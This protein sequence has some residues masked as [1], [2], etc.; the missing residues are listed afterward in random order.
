MGVWVSLA[1]VLAGG[2]SFLAFL[3][4]KEK[5]ES[6]SSTPSLKEKP[7]FNSKACQEKKESSKKVELHFGDGSTL[8][9]DESSPYYQDF[10]NYAD[11]ILSKEGENAKERAHNGSA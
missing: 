1:A 2:L 9:L 8:V 4:G 5:K 10:L 11:K 3:L 6:K 7:D